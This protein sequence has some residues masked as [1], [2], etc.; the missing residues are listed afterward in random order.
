MKVRKNISTEPAKLDSPHEDANHI[1]CVLLIIAQRDL[2]SLK[3]KRERT[4]LE[5]HRLSTNGVMSDYPTIWVMI[6]F[7]NF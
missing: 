2:N 1:S 5:E 6:K 4:I 7:H 3:V